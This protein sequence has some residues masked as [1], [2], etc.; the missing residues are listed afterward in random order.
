[1]D[2]RLAIVRVRSQSLLTKT[3]LLHHHLVGQPQECI[4][5]EPW[6]HNQANLP[7]YNIFKP[8]EASVSFS[9]KWGYMQHLAHVAVR[10][11]CNTITACPAQ[12]LAAG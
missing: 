5:E 9:E 2:S 7:G 8:C 4:F 1:M 6:L 11:G 10:L 3:S 12:D